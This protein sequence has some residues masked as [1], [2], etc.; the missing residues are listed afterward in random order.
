MKKNHS[1]QSFKLQ[2]YS[3]PIQPGIQFPV[4]GD[5]A[6]HQTGCRIHGSRSLPFLWLSSKQCMSDGETGALFRDARLKLGDPV[7][8]FFSQCRTHRDHVCIDPDLVPF[9]KGNMFQIYC[10]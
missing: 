2:I 7:Q 1:I 4:F 9:N 3:F 5:K 6:L 10:I 8:Q